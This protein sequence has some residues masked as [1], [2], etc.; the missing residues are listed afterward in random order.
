[1]RGFFSQTV[2]RYCELS[3]IDRSIPKAVTIPSID[4]HQLKPEE[5]ETRGELAGEA[6]KVL[7]KALYGARLVRY[8]LLWI[9]CSL[10]RC[11]TKWT[12]ACDRRLHKLI[13]Y[14]NSTLDYVLRGTVG[15]PMELLSLKLFADADFAGCEKTARSTSGVF[16]C[17]VGPNTFMPLAAISKKQTCVSHS[18]RR[19]NWWPLT[20]L[21]VPRAYRLSTCGRL[22][23]AGL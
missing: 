10:A 8:D 18:T 14:I 22:S 11:V 15:N 4:D 9:I 5:F 2:D 1:M 3:G 12:V 19:L 7:M 23:C 17:L 21:C 13:C 16:L 6:A 20:W